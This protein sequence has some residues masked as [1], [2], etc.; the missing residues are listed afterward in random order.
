M[1][2]IGIKTN[3]TVIVADYK[4]IPYGTWKDAFHFLLPLYQDYVEKNPYKKIV[5]MGI[6]PV[7]ASL[8]LSP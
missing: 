3:P 8:Y 2:K 6:L 4:L 5:L 7:V 1:K